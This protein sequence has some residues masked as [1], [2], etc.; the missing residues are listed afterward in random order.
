MESDE[1][2]P[3][4]RLRA[5]LFLSPSISREG[6]RPV[7]SSLTFRKPELGERN[8]SL[9]SSTHYCSPCPAGL[10]ARPTARRYLRAAATTVLTRAFGCRAS[11]WAPQTVPTP[12]PA[13][14]CSSVGGRELSACIA[15]GMRPG[16][17]S[18]AERGA[19]VMAK[20][21]AWGE[22]GRGV[23][24]CSWVTV[25]DAGERAAEVHYVSGGM[26]ITGGWGR[27]GQ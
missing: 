5:Q 3:E 1:V 16:S 14:R 4:L 24:R 15:G 9:S 20:K 13:P 22:G 23:S 25:S 18:L 7:S 17:G 27:K 12:A 8:C 19:A 10:Q 6:N 21:R 26:N 2:H 11:P